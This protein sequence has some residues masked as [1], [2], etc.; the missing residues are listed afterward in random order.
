[1]CTVYLQHEYAKSF[2]DDAI[3][4]DLNELARRDAF[5]EK[6]HQELQIYVDGSDLVAE[7]QDVGT[8]FE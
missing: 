1:M 6:I 7:I 2:F 5:L 8:L 4:P 3:H